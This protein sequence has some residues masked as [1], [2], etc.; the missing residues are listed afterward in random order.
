MIREIRSPFLLF[1]MPHLNSNIPM[2]QMILCI[3]RVSNFKAYQN[4]LGHEYLCNTFQSPFN[5]NAEIRK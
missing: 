5:G 2:I 3:Y 4:F 1:C